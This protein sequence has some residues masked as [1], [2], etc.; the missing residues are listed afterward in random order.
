VLHRGGEVESKP[1]TDQVRQALARWPKG[2][3]SKYRARLGWLLNKKFAGKTLKQKVPAR[4]I[5]GITPQTMRDV[6]EAVGVRIL[7]TR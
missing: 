3:G 7:E 4:R 2:G 6:K 5:V 1:I